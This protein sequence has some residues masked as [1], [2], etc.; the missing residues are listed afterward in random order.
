MLTQRLDYTDRWC[1]IGSKQ[2]GSKFPEIDLFKDVYVQPG[3]ETSEQLHVAMVEKGVI[4][5]QEVTSQLPPETPIEDVTVPEDVGFEI[6]TEVLNQKFSRCHGKVVRGI[7]KA[8]VRETGASSSRSTTG[9]VNALK[10]E[11]ATLKGQ[12]VAQDKQIKAKS[13]QMKAQS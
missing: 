9:E 8:R 11:V 12:L 7:G 10:E 5:L 4:V 13:E 3:D 1:K 2:E 6:M